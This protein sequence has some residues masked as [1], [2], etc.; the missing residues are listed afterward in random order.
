MFS[1]IVKSSVMCMIACVKARVNMKYRIDKT[2]P[3]AATS[4]KR[5]AVELSRSNKKMMDKKAATPHLFKVTLLPVLLL[6]SPPLRPSSR[7]Q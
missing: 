4:S 2:N 6:P 1:A 5:Y 7:T 3:A